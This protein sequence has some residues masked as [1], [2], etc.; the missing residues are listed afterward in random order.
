M[1]RFK[2]FCLHILIMLVLASPMVAEGQSGCRLNS[3]CPVGNICSDG[4]CVTDPVCS[5]SPTPCWCPGVTCPEG[6]VCILGQSNYCFIPECISD[7][8]CQLGEVCSSGS[9]VVDVFADRDRDGVPD[10]TDNCSL[11]VNTGQDDLDEDGQGDICDDDDDDD[12]VPDSS[13]NC[14]Q[15][16]NPNQYDRDNNGVGNFC[17]LNHPQVTVSLNCSAFLNGPGA[18]DTD[19][20]DIVDVCDKCKFLASAQNFDSDGDGFGDACDPDKDGDDI[21]NVEDNC[22]GIPNQDQADCNCNGMGDACDTLV[23]DATYCA[24]L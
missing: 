7:L 4:S 14:P 6:S 1:K 5:G 9:C 15:T 19:G 23:C 13:D 12:G 24:S 8:D 11:I 17:E 2:Y 3:D 18:I 10:N 16:S 21:R 22:P 20:D